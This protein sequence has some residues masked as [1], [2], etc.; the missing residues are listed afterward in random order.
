MYIVP[1]DL[2]EVPFGNIEVT[3]RMGEG[4][5]VLASCCR[6]SAQTHRTHAASPARDDPKLKP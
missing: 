1:V 3:R 4:R 5:Q 2:C 6:E